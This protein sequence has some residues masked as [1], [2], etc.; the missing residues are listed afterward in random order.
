MAA[1]LVWALAI[2]QSLQLI[3]VA[4]ASSAKATNTSMERFA[5]TVQQVVKNALITLWITSHLALFA[6]LHSF[7]LEDFV[8]ALQV[9]WLWTINASNKFCVLPINMWLQITR[10]LH[11]APFA[12]PVHPRL[13]FA[14]NASTKVSMLLTRQKT[15]FALFVTHAS[16]TSLKVNADVNKDRC[17]INNRTLVLLLKL[18]QKVITWTPRLISVLHALQPLIIF[19]LLVIPLQDSV[20]N[21]LIQL[22][23]LMELLVSPTALKPPSSLATSASHRSNA[24]TTPT[25]TARTIARTAHSSAKFA[26]TQLVSALNVNQLTLSTLTPTPV[27][28]SSTNT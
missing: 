15:L 5:K 28:V 11:A 10:V 27:H 14:L 24:P 8:V 1:V 6:L 9:K 13:E 7:F 3:H 4:I 23:W 22:F 26:Q 16:L 18:V 17:S 12:R 25:T 19:A 2:P 20:I 21:Q